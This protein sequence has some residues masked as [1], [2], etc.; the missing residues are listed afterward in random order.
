MKRVIIESPYAG[1]IERNTEYARRCLKDSLDRGEA[2]LA[3][4]LLYPQV[5]D[6]ND[7]KQRQQ[8][9]NAGTAWMSMRVEEKL[10][11]KEEDYVTVAFYVDYGISEGM[12]SAIGTA[13][14]WRCN[15]DIR[16]IGKNPG[17]ADG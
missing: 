14:K 3:S 1:D 13:R 12:R 11:D 16:T 4:H 10:Y 15:L 8:G 9:I 17:D 5:L 6:E 7:P 2:P